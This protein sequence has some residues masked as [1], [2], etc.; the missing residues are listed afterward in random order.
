MAYTLIEHKEWIM[1]IMMKSVMIGDT[2]IYCQICEI[3]QKHLIFEG[4]KNCSEVKT[5]KHFQSNLS[6]WARWNLEP[7]D[8]HKKGSLD[9]FWNNFL[10]KM[11]IGK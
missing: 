9:K 7:K 10:K 8:K 6:Y 11:K 3:C 2:W 5:K 1:K 4:M